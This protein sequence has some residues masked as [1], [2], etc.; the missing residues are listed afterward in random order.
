VLSGRGLC[1][2]LNTRPEESYRLCC[3][4]VCDLET[5][6][7][8]APYIYDIS[9]LRVNFRFIVSFNNILFFINILNFNGARGSAV[10]WGT[11]LQAGRFAG[12]IPVGVIGIFQW[13]NPSGRTMALGLTQPLIEMSIRNICWGGKGGRCLGL[14]TLHLHVPIVLKSRSLNLLKPSGPV[15][16]CNGIA[17]PLLTSLRFPIILHKM[18]ISRFFKTSCI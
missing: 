6:R 16:A 8:G 11:A 12:S 14:T 15:Q 5:L 13:H 9:R 7:I 1:D 10:G 3:V 17:L 4:V 2:E 18:T